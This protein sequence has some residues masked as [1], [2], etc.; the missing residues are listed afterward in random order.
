MSASQ[1]PNLNTL[2]SARSSTRGG[3]GRGNHHGGPPSGGPSTAESDSQKDKVVQQTDQDASVSRMSAVELGYLDDPFAH[4]F[5]L[6][7]APRKFPII[8]RGTF[9]RTTA[10]DD[11]VNR[12]LASNPSQKKQIISLGAGSDT[13]YFR[14]RKSAN[15]SPSLIYHEIDFPANTRQ[16]ITAIRHSPE[17]T[18]LLQSASNSSD[19]SITVSEDESALHTPT[20]HIHPLDLRTLSVPQ[21]QSHGSETPNAQTSLIPHIDAAIPTLLLSECCLIYLPPTAADNILKYFTSQ[22]LAPSTP[23]SLIVYEPINP[24]SDAFGAMMV[25]NLAARGIV[26]QTLKKYSSLSRQRERMR[27]MG[28]A[29][30]QGAADVDFIWE[31]WVSD[32]EKERVA[33]LEMLDEVE[34]WRL[35]AR[36]YCVAWGWREVSAGQGTGTSQDVEAHDR[37]GSVFEGWRDVAAQSSVD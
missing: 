5:T 29:S 7:K 3:R 31:R 26:L 20:Y 33:G 18:S 22:L 16:K 37:G 12:F 32:D 34:E 1:I 4:H 25:S 10:I 36:H 13:R 14:L 23:L 9:V 8:N 19:P 15:P 35:L 6:E 28:F 17:M 21:Q 30:G 2:R 24:A 27:M 11:L